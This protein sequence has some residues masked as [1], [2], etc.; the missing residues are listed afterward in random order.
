MERSGCSRTSYSVSHSGLCHCLRSRFCNSGATGISFQIMPCCWGWGCV[1]GRGPCALWHL[2][3][4]S[5]TNPPPP[6]LATK[7]VSRYCQTSQSAPVIPLKN[8][9]EVGLLRHRVVTCP[10]QGH[11]ASKQ[12]HWCEGPCLSDSGDYVIT[13]CRCTCGQR[14]SGSDLGFSSERGWCGQTGY[15]G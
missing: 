13:C 9:C 15:L 1:A 3:D 5:I 2:H 6:V 8:S 7:N 14:N 4:A 11:T 10:A 12:S